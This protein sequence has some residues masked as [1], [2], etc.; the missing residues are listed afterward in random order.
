MER[1][2]KIA[3]APSSDDPPADDGRISRVLDRN[4]DV[5]LSRQD[6]AESAMTLQTRVA[7]AITRFVGSMPFV[8]I[9]L[10][11][12]VLWVLANVGW[13]PPIPVFDPSFVMLAMI[14]S[15][16]AIFITTFVL[17]S[18]NRMMEME[19]RR[20]DLNLQISLLAEHETT[21]LIALVSAIAERLD[22]ETDVNPE[23]LDDLKQT[24]SPEAVLN[25]I[26]RKRKS[27]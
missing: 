8:Y 18:Q 19:S 25:Q 15:V 16:E 7:D 20:A 14:A 3:E 6:A 9:H 27:D 13:L 1:P 22:V 5:L 12:V 17:I 2:P 10:A 26:E 24:V 4:I 21:R 23:E 11:A